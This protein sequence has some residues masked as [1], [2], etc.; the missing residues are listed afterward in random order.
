MLRLGLGHAAWR[1]EQQLLLEDGL[2]P[3]ETLRGHLCKGP[4]VGGAQKGRLKQDIRSVFSPN[5]DI[6]LLGS[7]A[8]QSAESQD[9]ERVQEEE[10]QPLPGMEE[11]SQPHCSGATDRNLHNLTAL[12]EGAS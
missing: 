11:P 2:M 7:S 8:H 6:Q 5:L 4:R 12:S 3:A 9:G 1:E 10:L